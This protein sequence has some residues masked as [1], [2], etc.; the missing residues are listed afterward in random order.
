VNCAQEL[1]KQDI[2]GV[3]SIKLF[4]D[5]MPHAIIN[6]YFDRIADKIQDHANRG[7]RTV[8]HCVCGISRAASLTIAYLMKHK[9]MG[10]R[11]AH[12]YVLGRRRVIRPNQGNSDTCLFIVGCGLG[13]KSRR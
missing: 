10:L 6:V 3:E 7:G 5:D 12:E 2:T 1:P 13:T 11:A 4:L 9:G 8:I